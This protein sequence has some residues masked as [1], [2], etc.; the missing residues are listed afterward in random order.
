MRLPPGG[1]S[2]AESAHRMHRFPCKAEPLLFVQSSSLRIDP[3]AF[4]LELPAALAWATR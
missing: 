1:R 4:D 3:P 2:R